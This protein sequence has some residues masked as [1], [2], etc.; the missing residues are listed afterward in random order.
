MPNPKNPDPLSAAMYGTSGCLTTPSTTISGLYAC[1]S[2]GELPIN[3][4]KKEGFS[5]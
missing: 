4:F 3:L 5:I 2:T 1:P